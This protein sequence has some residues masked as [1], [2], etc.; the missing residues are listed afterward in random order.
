MN[1]Q[2]PFPSP[3]RPSLTGFDTVGLAFAGFA[4]LWAAFAVVQVQPTFSK[5]FSDF[6]DPPPA[7][8]QLCIQPWFPLAM[9]IVPLGVA[10]IGLL[11]PAPR[12]VRAVLLGLT[13][14]SSLAG[15]GVLLR[16]LYMPV[17]TLVG[18]I[19]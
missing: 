11:R 3:S 9:G 10:C 13:I 5:M 7:F 14:F 18:R 4:L 16:G 6:R 8:T 19:K 12:R 15:P 17:F 1:A 2:G